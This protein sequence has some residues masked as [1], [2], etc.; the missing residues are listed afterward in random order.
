MYHVG[1]NLANSTLLLKALF[2]KDVPVNVFPLFVY[3]LLDGEINHPHRGFTNP[4]LV[5]F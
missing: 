4:V 3:M 2:K 5:T 1:S